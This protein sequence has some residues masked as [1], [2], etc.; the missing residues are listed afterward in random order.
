MSLSP[1][2]GSDGR[3]DSYGSKGISGFNTFAPKVL[4]LS[5][6][7]GDPWVERR[8]ARV[9][10]EALGRDNGKRDER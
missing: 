7:G 2:P 8:G 10:Q 3:Q 1:G 5:G 4:R 6:E 9:A